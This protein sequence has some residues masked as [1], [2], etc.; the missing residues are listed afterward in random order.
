[1]EYL[2]PTFTWKQ[3]Y[4]SAIEEGFEP[5]EASERATRQLPRVLR[6]RETRVFDG[7]AKAA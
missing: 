3:L 6:M 4:W 5:W 2:D 1:M 7:E